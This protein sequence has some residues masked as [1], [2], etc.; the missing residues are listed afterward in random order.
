MQVRNPIRKYYHTCTECAALTYYCPSDK[1]SNCLKVIPEGVTPQERR[2][3][4]NDRHRDKKHKL[5]R[6]AAAAAAAASI[7][8]AAP[9][10]DPIIEK[11]EENLK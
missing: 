11:I 4:Y 9:S 3:I 10:V 8:D 2:K 5:K 1:A 6:E 7:E